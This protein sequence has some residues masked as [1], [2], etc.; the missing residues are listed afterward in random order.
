MAFNCKCLQRV[1]QEASTVV[2][3]DVREGLAALITDGELYL[4]VRQ[5]APNKSPGWNGITFEYYIMYW[6]VNKDIM[7]IFYNQMVQQTKITAAQKQGCY[8]AFQKKTPMEPESYSLSLF[9]TETTSF[10]CVFWRIV[11]DKLSTV[12]C[13]SQYCGM[14]SRTM[15]DAIAVIHES[16]A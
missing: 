7:L 2:P 4:A 3:M 1:E 13:P 6:A 5:G 14:S 11:C 9:S 15:F 12:V 16:L 8:C 10:R